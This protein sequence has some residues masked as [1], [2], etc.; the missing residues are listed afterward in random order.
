MGRSLVLPSRGG[1]TYPPSA[2]CGGLRK[3]KKRRL[4]GEIS[5]QVEIAELAFRVDEASPD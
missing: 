5:W 3:L 1:C 4:P 2:T